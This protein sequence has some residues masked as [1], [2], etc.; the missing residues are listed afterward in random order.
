MPLV[1]ELNPPWSCGPVALGGSQRATARALRAWGDV[2]EFAPWPGGPPLDTIVKAGGVNVVVGSNMEDVVQHVT[3][4]RDFDFTPRPQVMLQGIDVFAVPVAEVVAVLEKTYGFENGHHLECTV[5]G[6]L[7]TLG[8]DEVPR[9]NSD[10]ETR[11]RY[12]SFH[13][14]QMFRR[15]YF[16]VL[17]GS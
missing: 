17:P 12:R 11:E 13:Y 10:D 6:L 14:V 16:D 1:I 4:S 5:P 2:E 8:R 15:G 3:V 7:L 9:E